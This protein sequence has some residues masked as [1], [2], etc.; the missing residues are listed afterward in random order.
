[1]LTVDYDRLGLLAGDRVLDLG[2]GFGRH[3]FEAA[4]RGGEV[5]ALD[6][7]EDELRDVRAMFLAM[8]TEGELDERRCHAGAVRADG[9]RLPFAS[10]A[11]DRVIAAEVLEHIPDDMGAMAELARVLRPDGTM[12]VT[13]PRCG[14]EA[15]NWLLSDAYHDVPGGHVRIY[16]RS[17]LVRRFSACGLVPVGHHHAHGLHSPYWWLRC[18]VGPANDAHRAVAAYHRLLVW[19]IVKRPRVTRAAAR[20]LDPLIGKSMV[21]YFHKPP[22]AVAEARQLHTTP[23]EAV[24]A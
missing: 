4:R 2:C 3:A 10:G 8:V 11:F 18:L 24:A 7:G 9:L 13:V 6:A 14:P 12:A 20:V 21:V 23:A 15:V 22:A 19:E 5:V 1:M 16:R 17:I